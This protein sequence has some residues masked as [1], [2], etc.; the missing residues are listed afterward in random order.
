MKQ[1]L[2]VQP[3]QHR[4]QEPPEVHRRERRAYKEMA[5]E[6]GVFSTMSAVHGR[7]YSK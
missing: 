4:H 2:T 1:F 7:Y 6:N 3:S 5:T